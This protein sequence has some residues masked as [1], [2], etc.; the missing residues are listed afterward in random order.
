MALPV[1]R[2]PLTRAAVCARAQAVEIHTAVTGSRPLGL[3]QGKPN[4]RTRRLLVE[5]GGFVYVSCFPSVAVVLDCVVV[6]VC[7]SPHWQVRL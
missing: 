4:E 5:E 2:L 1:G 3:Y 7:S 6:D